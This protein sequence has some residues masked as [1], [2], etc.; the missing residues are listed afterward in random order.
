MS[1]GNLCF[2]NDKGIYGVDQSAEELLKT[3]K[4]YKDPVPRVYKHDTNFKL[5]RGGHGHTIGK[6]PGVMPTKP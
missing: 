3:K 5:A 1:H 2:G 6:D 4:M